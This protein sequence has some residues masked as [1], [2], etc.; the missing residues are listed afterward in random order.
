MRYLIK[1]FINLFS[2]C[3]FVISCATSEPKREVSF[4]V[5]DLENNYLINSSSVMLN[6]NNPKLNDM[7]CLTKD[8]IIYLY[9]NIGEDN[10]Q[11]LD[12]NTSLEGNR[13]PK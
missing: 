6:Y 4:W 9:K 8:D 7:A 3:I 13:Q 10:G 5:F 12:S 11:C 1:K 2:L